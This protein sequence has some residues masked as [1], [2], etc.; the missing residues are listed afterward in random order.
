M[1]DGNILDVSESLTKI[2][3]H[4]KELVPQCPPD[5]RSDA[6]KADYFRKAVSQF[7]DFSSILI[8]NITSQGYIL[9]N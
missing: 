9:T 4:I 8:Q 6:H 7:Q 1:S 3:S 5:F 2:I